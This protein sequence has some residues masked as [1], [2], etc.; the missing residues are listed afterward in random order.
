MMTNELLLKEHS[1][2]YDEP[3]GKYG[4]AFFKK[5]RFFLSQKWIHKII[6]FRGSLL[7]PD[8]R[9]LEWKSNSFFTGG[10]YNS[11][12]NYIWGRI[13]T[14]FVDETSRQPTRVLND[15]L[16]FVIISEPVTSWQILTHELKSSAPMYNFFSGQY[17]KVNFFWFL[18]HFIIL[19]Y[20]TNFI[21]SE[22]Q[23]YW[24]LKKRT[25]YNVNL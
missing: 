21:F 25:A 6:F 7:A 3:I 12:G 14:I 22:Y 17:S 24:A 20:K 10:L 18:K 15:F 11:V 1:F 23:I 19:F 16:S 9:L 5:N 8:I 2:L 4:G 13:R